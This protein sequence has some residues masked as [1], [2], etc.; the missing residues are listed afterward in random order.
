M[1]AATSRILPLTA[2]AGPSP[3]SP[4]SLLTLGFRGD[5]HF[6]SRTD[7]QHTHNPTISEKSA[8]PEF[9]ERHVLRRK[10]TRRTAERLAQV[11][12]AATEIGTLP[13]I[14]ETIHMIMH[15]SYHGWSTVGGVLKLASPATIATLIV[16][17]LGFNAAN[18]S[19]L[20]DMLDDGRV[21]CVRFV[22]SCYFQ[23][24]C[25]REFEV[26]R[27]GLESRGQQLAALRTHAKIIGCALTDGRQF[28]VETSANLRSCRNIEQLTLTQSA[29][30]FA[31]H[32]YWITRAI[33][34]C[35]G[36]ASP[37]T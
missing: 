11:D 29:S 1:D 16:A 24:S 34:Q 37:P 5:T 25:P 3:L 35:R 2:S 33:Q 7:A 28:V 27:A 21:G 14:D 17:T 15:G 12:K 30:L 18:A 10:T 13:D 36:S 9:A 8:V 20:L 31:F 4:S 22:C 6:L 19:E 23:K 32:D 26:L